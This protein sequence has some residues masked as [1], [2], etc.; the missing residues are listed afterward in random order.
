[1]TN[2]WFGQTEAVDCAEERKSPVRSP[3]HTR[4]PRNGRR[5]S[6]RPNL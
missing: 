4:L 2:Q 1:M 6:Q 5:A 3:L